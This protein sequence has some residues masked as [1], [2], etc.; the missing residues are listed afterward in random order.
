MQPEGDIVVYSAQ[1]RLDGEM[2]RIFLES[3]GITA[4]LSQESAGLVHGFTVGPLGLV[5]ILVPANQ[6]SQAVDLIERMLQGEFELPAGDPE[7]D[8]DDFPGE[9]EQA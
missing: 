3:Q 4:R 6:A 2:I 7:E 8:I 9:D 1:G 5:D